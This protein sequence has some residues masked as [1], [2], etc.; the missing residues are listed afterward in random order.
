MSDEPTESSARELAVA[1]GS[2]RSV[3]SV[4]TRPG[5]AVGPA[6]RTAVL[7][8]LGIALPLTVRSHHDFAARLDTSDEWIRAR[9]GIVERRVAGPDIA[10]SDLAFEAGRKAIQQRAMY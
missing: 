10:A 1:G 8:G 3:S 5:R 9:T 6:T 4:A 7:D 2:P